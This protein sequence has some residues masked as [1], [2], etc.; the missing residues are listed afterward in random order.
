MQLTKE[1]RA[2]IVEEHFRTHSFQQVYYSFAERFPERL[3]PIV[4]REML[5]K[6]EP[7]ERA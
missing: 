7:K 2:F 1:Q 6:T 4:F 5:L 3:F